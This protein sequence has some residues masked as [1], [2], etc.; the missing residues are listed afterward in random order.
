MRQKFLFF[1][2]V[3]LAFMLCQ[4]SDKNK[5]T[6]EFNKYVAGYTSGQVSRGASVLLILS[7]EVSEEQ[8]KNVNLSELMSISP[9]VDGAFSFSDG[10]TIVFRPSGEMQYDTEYK[11]EA[12]LSKLF[13]NADKFAFSFKTLPF[14]MSAALSDFSVE[15]SGDY[16]YAF[17][18]NSADNESVDRVKSVIEL[19]QGG[20]NV[21]DLTW[22]KKSDRSFTVVA[23]VR[24]SSS[25]LEVNTIANSE[26]GLEAEN[27]VS[28]DVPNPNELSVFDVKCVNGDTRYIEV[29]FNKI[30]DNKQDMMGLAYVE[31]NTSMVVETDGNKLKLFPDLSTNGEV[32]VVLSENI[33]SKDGMLLGTNVTRKVD[34]K[35]NKPAVEFI[36]DGV[37]I[38]QTDKLVVPFRSIYMKGVRVNVFKIYANNF[39]LW[40]QNA[41]LYDSDPLRLYGRPIAT[42]TFFMDEIDDLSKWHN[43]S[44]DLSDLMKV[45]PGCMYRV[46]LLMDY[47]LSAWP[48]CESTSLDKSVFEREDKVRLASLNENFDNGDNW[49]NIQE[50]WS[51]Y[52][53]KEAEDPTKNSYYMGKS[54]GKN[55]FATNIGLW[56]VSPTSKS[57]VVVASDL[58]TAKGMSGVFVEAYNRQNQ[59]IGKGE[60]NVDGRVD[61]S[62]DGSNGSPFIVLAK[63]DNDVSGLRVKRGEELSTS[64]FEVAGDVVQ[65]GMKGYI[66]GERGVWRPG[67][68][69]FLSFIL[70]DRAKTLPEN[71][72]VVMEICNPLGQTY[73]TFTK[74]VGKMGVYAFPVPTEDNIVTGSW[75][76]NVQVGGTTFSKR[77]RIE[78]IKPNRLKIN[79]ALPNELIEGAQVY[80]LRTEWLNGA[81]THEMK[82]EISTKV[83]KGKTKFDKWKDYEFDDCSKS[84]DAVETVVAEGKTDGNGEAYMN[85]YMPKTTAAPGK[86]NCS[87]TTKVYEPSGEF[88]TDVQ[89]VPF[90]PYKQYV[91]VKAPSMGDKWFLA[92]GKN[93]KFEVASV[94]RNGVGV[95]SNLTVEVYK[96]AWWWWWNSTSEGV[97]DYSYSFYDKPFKKETI[98][99]DG[100]GKGSFV[101]N[102][103][104]KDWGGFLIRVTDNRGGHTACIR[105][106]FDWPSLT[107]RRASDGGAFVTALSIQTD[108]KEYVAGDKMQV[109]IPSAQGGRAIVTVSNSAGIQEMKFV[110]CNAGNTTVLFDVTEEMLPNVYVSATLIQPY[111]HTKDNDMPIRLYGVVPVSVSSESSKLTP[112]IESKDETKPLQTFKVKVKEEKGRAMAYTLAVVDEGLLD[113]T[114]FKTPNAWNAFF[115]KEA[116]SMRIWDLYSNVCGAFGGKIDQMFTVGGDEA[117]YNGPKA[118]V[119]RFT[120]MVYFG[121]PF[122]VEKGK[123]N[124]HEIEVPNY[125]GR[126]RVMVVAADGNAYGSAEKSVFVRK[127]MMVTG[128]MPRQIGVGDETTV[129][130]TI[131]AMD[132]SVKNVKTTISVSGD[133][134]VVGS[135]S[136]STDFSEQGDKTV[137]F[138]VKAGNQEGTGTIT[139]NSTC[140]GDKSVYAAELPIRSVSD[141]MVNCETFK[142]EAGKSEERIVKALGNEKQ[143]LS[144]EV[145]RIKPFNV[146]SRVES[147]LDFPYASSECIA[148]K[149][150][151]QIY[152]MEFSQLSKEQSVQAE[153]N[154]KEAIESLVAYQNNE[155][156]MAYWKNSGFGDRWTSAYVLL[157]LKKASEKGYYVNDKMLR[158]LTRYVQTQVRNWKSSSS[159]YENNFT[160][161]GLYVL[162]STNTSNAQELGTMNRMKANVGKMSE[163]AQNY[164]A[165]AYASVGQIAVAKQIIQSVAGD[166]SAYRCPISSSR[167]ISQTLCGLTSVEQSVEDMRAK[168]TSQDWMYCTDVVLSLHAASVY[169]K[170][171]GV[172]E[173]LNFSLSVNGK[174]YANEKTTLSAWSAQ[175]AK[176]QQQAKVKVQNKGKA[177]Q[178]ATAFF[179]SWATQASVPASAS[180]LSV[181]V[182]YKKDNSILNLQSVE[183]GATYKAV[184]SV[185]NLTGREQENVAISYIAPAGIEILK[186]ANDLYNVSIDQ[187]DDR[188]YIYVDNLKRGQTTTTTLTLSATYAGN[189]YVPYIVAKC[190]Y[191]NNVMG[192]TASSR[193]VVK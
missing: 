2:S 20:S 31:D 128:T 165:A 93:Q 122:I 58:L 39:A 28:V 184:V 116:M 130:A 191:D 16:K 159:D 5:S 57:L 101:L 109:T 163:G 162:A 76:V 188:T 34:L 181:N 81:K 102:V 190:I 119:N 98:N 44:I 120:P 33:R 127:S 169:C 46:E 144:V 143:L 148:S 64:A 150:L 189:Y 45:E 21:N 173:E 56:A 65:K 60:T 12:D 112:I 27:L 175:V 157:F 183:A 38:P 19:K 30:L 61:F 117:L 59:L 97:A 37:I 124:T 91:G 152:L 99:T 187:R 158:S 168:L 129:S 13:D 107:E 161:F 154:V 63:K 145:S 182:V 17:Q 178:Y 40:L 10:H 113:L 164:L 89:I 72:P 151:G 32:T 149:A 92:T 176:N 103:K 50:D 192:N 48:G 23:K 177:T 125:S 83:V 114:R 100:N 160:A 42:T 87:V 146:A 153:K 96:T 8:Q 79:L 49:Y 41:S 11:V 52:S 1:I 43:Y 66:Y 118:I 132:N 138:K 142:I 90:S 82:Y 121:G 170:K 47:R 86:L 137:Q 7:E 3:M 167:V 14:Q 123:T 55:V 172:D 156:A 115:A 180:G 94:D 147:L 74:T 155:G 78:T 166:A 6:E 77:I 70:N 25:T 185:T 88:S 179:E 95:S 139:I 24:F 9:S 62:F 68:T 141:R 108:K 186:V 36:G 26:Y 104:D 171:N 131:F 105:S 80:D 53:W 18:V 126:V 15:E 73:K 85:L 193:M 135:N 134:E 54:K 51:N 69:L 174:E 67:D 111:N 22:E 84:F 110:D 29:S 140:S 106:Y 136:V 75:L 133:L 35:S 4:C 71:H